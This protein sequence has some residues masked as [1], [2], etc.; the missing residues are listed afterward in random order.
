MAF[1]LAVTVASP[2]ISK[3]LAERPLPYCNP[4]AIIRYLIESNPF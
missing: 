3:G 1:V 2:L 4:P